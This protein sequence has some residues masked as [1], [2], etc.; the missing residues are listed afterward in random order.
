M[1]LTAS[2][3]DSGSSDNCDDFMITIDK[4]E[5]TVTDLGENTVTLTVIDAVGNEASCTAIV[6]V[7][8]N[9]LP[10]A[11]CKS[12]T[13]QLDETGN[14]TI[15]A[16]SVNDG[17]FDAGGIQSI[18]IFPNTFDCTQIGTVTTEL[19]VVDT[20]GNSS[21]CAV[22][23]VIEEKVLPEILCEVGKDL[24]SNDGNPVVVTIVSPNVS[25]NCDESPIV[26]GKR[27][28][29]LDM[30]APYPVGVTT[31]IWTAIDGS[32][33]VV[34][35][36]QAVSVTFSPRTGNEIITFSIE[37]QIGNTSI[38]LEEKEVCIVM[39]FESDL[40]NI[41][42]LI[43]VSLGAI[44]SPESE[45]TQNF[46]SAVEYTVTAENKEEEKWTIIVTIEVDNILPTIVCV[47]DI[48]VSNDKGLCGA[49]VNFFITSSDNSPGEIIEQI[50][51]LES[52]AYFSTGETI[53][54]FVVTDTS[55]NKA[56]CSFTIKVV[57]DENPIAKCKSITLQ[58]DASGAA[59]ITWM[60]VNDGSSDNC[61]I[62]DYMVIPSRFTTADIG[63]NLVVF[64]VTDSYG[65]S[66]NCEINVNVSV[67]KKEEIW[68]EAE[69][70]IVGGNWDFCK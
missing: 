4:T 34:E 45:D 40:T 51:G 10:I 67:A 31:I 36:S 49:V 48:I 64:T 43:A 46:E 59:E 70:G 16:E 15:M 29:E 60:D 61:R 23:L 66:S 50:E 47:E 35:C 19:T 26:N 20:S 68:L 22:Q 21:K 30:E 44:I 3:I 11:K 53:N 18:S 8:D 39:P 13:V 65:N 55:G 6:T 56:T 63:D 9:I 2:D 58:L 57:D 52:G 12:L 32:G 7:I 38:N 33:N 37:N 5:F 69:C 54:T 42:P 27:S 14:V 1:S 62:V 41:N 24:I 17:S 25:D 28:D